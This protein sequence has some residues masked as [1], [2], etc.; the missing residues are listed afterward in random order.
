MRI[1]LATSLRRALLPQDA[2]GAVAQSNF[3][4]VRAA[5]AG[6]EDDLHVSIQ[7]SQT[8]QLLRQL[9]HGAFATQEHDLWIL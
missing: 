4:E 1:V 9:F 6:E 5:I 7:L 3:V 2:F 8:M